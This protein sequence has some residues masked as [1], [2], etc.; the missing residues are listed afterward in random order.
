MRWAILPDLVPEGAAMNLRRRVRSFAIVATLAVAVAATARVAPAQQRFEWPEKA[1]NLKVLPKNTPKE[2][3]SATMIGFTRA[4]GVRCPFCHVGQ[5][6]QPL[7]TYDFGSDQKP[8]K[9]VARG[10]MKLV[11][12]T[13][14]EIRKM[15]VPEP[16][17]VEVACITCH[18]GRPRPMT[19]ADE[20]ALVYGSAG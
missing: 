2:K 4:L 12:K 19:L 13:N 18:R 7:T 1:K 6:G 10:M 20:L 5:E 15:N 3:L 14:D 9:Q 16:K 11:K 8:M 17:H